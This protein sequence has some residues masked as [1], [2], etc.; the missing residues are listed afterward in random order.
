MESLIHSMKGNPSSNTL[1]QLIIQDPLVLHQVL[2][3]ADPHNSHQVEAQ[4]GMCQPLTQGKCLLQWTQ[5]MGSRMLQ[6]MIQTH[7]Q[8]ACPLTTQVCHQHSPQECQLMTQVCSHLQ[9]LKDSQWC[10]PLEQ[11]LLI[12]QQTQFLNPRLKTK[13]TPFLS[14]PLTSLK[15]QPLMILRQE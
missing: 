11:G 1:H 9:L 12:S 14:H 5:T 10:S 2:L 15:T 7:N 6:A 13:H 3:Q 8:W 4:E